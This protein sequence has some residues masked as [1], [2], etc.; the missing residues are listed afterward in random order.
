MRHNNW[1][2]CSFLLLDSI[3]YFLRNLP[4]IYEFY[5]KSSSYYNCVGMLYGEDNVYLFRLRLLVQCS[6]SYILQNGNPPLSDH[7][8]TYKFTLTPLYIFRV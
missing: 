4:R 2:I 1:C 8:C 3:R 5:D 6:R 7:R